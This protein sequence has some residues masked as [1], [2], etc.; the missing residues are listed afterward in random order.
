MKNNKGFDL[1]EELV[2][3][4]KEQAM[5]ERINMISSIIFEIVKQRNEKKLSQRDIE[6]ITGIKQP[7]IARIETL[8]SIPRLDTLVSLC[9]AVG[10]KLGTIPME[11]DIIPL[12]LNIKIK[13]DAEPQEPNIHYIMEKPAFFTA[14]QVC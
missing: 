9:Q 2:L 7:M 10:I 1:F 6:E 3:T 8:K 13:V 11:E 4:D 12:N 5:V 14:G